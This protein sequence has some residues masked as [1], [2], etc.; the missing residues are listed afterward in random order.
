M[1]L[2]KNNGKK[3]DTIVEVLIALT[4]LSLAMSISYSI[5][6][7]SIMALAVARKNAEAT[8]LLQQQVE[9]LRITDLSAWTDNANSYCIPEPNNGVAPVLKLSTDVSCTNMDGFQISISRRETDNPNIYTTKAAWQM[10]SK[11]YTAEMTYVYN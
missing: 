10:G 11:Q 5:A 4:I 6:N 8:A 1:I 9:Y 3:G 2:F 7:S